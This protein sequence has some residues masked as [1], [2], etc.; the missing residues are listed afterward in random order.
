MTLKK[1]HTEN[2]IFYHSSALHNSELKKDIESI[3]Y[4][5]LDESLISSS[6]VLLFLDA[7]NG[8]I[9]FLPYDDTIKD[10]KNGKELWLLL[11]ELWADNDN[12]H[13]FEEIVTTGLSKALKTASGQKLLS[14]HELF[15]QTEMNKTVRL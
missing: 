3:F 7:T 6:Q 2:I 10:T 8:H 5:I 4:I 12:A 11:N 13:D 15:F 9:A 1:E 14:K